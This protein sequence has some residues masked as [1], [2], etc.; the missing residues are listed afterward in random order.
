MRTFAADVYLCYPKFTFV[1]K[2]Y[3]PVGEDFG[4]YAKCLR[5]VDGAIYKTIAEHAPDH[6]VPEIGYYVELKVVP[7]G[8]CALPWLEFMLRCNGKPVMQW[9][10]HQQPMHVVKEEELL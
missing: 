3:Y 5:T 4:E 8:S 1:G 10:T 9:E 2:L 6:G 7:E